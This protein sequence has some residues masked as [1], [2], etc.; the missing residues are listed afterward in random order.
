M[1][2]GGKNKSV[3]FIIVFSVYIYIC[4]EMGCVH[5]INVDCNLNRTILLLAD[6]FQR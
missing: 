3:S 4:M 5:K 6:G 1:K 2:N